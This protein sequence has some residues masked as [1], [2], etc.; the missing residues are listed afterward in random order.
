MLQAV[1]VGLKKSEGREALR[2]GPRARGLLTSA[3]RADIQYLYKL[4]L[5][6]H[7]LKI[8]NVPIK[9]DMG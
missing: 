9:I 6:V 5:V 1:V 7:S 8:F 2:T 3:V 4:E